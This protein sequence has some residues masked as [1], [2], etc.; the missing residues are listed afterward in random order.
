MPATVEQ[1]TF[2]AAPAYGPRNRS[3]ARFP[4]CCWSPRP[5][6]WQRS[7][8]MPITKFAVVMD[9][10]IGAGKFRFEIRGVAFPASRDDATIQFRPAVDKEFVVLHAIR[11]Y[12]FGLDAQMMF[13][14]EPN[15]T[16]IVFLL[17]GATSD[18]VPSYRS[19]SALSAW[20]RAHTSSHIRCAEPATVSCCVPRGGSVLPQTVPHEC[21]VGRN[22]T[23]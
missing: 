1:D 3:S 23:Q 16:K 11:K 21:V 19:L 15:V 2:D 22:S 18:G 10:G 13:S 17:A 5:G 20:H 4:P 7:R 14:P 12:K 8:E 6:L 9:V